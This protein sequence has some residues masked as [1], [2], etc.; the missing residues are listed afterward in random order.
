VAV[1]GLDDLERASAVG[2]CEG[3]EL[4]DPEAEDSYGL[5]PT[6]S[7]SDISKISKASRTLRFEVEMSAVSAF[8]AATGRSIQVRSG[9]RPVG[10]MSISS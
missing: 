7:G 10:K 2:W 6:G 3:I 5:Q 9:V 1:L 4:T 8:R